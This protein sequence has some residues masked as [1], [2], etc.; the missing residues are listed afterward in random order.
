MGLIVQKYGGTSVAT[1][2][3]IKSVAD[4]II[5]SCADSHR[6]VVVVSAMGDTTDDLIA[7][8]SQVSSDPDD[9]ELDLLLST[10]ETIS[11]TLMAMALRAK[12]RDAISLTGG[13]AGIRTERAH[14]RA[15][16]T[17]IEPSRMLR[18]L[19]LGRVVIV[20]GFQGIT[21]DMDVTTLGRGGSDTT[22]VALAVALQADRCEF[23]KDVDGVL[24]ADPRIVPRARK[25]DEIEYEEMLELAQHGANVLHHRAVELA[26]VYG[27]P[28]VVRSS[29]N[30]SPGTYIHGG[31]GMEIRNK[32]R[33]IAHDI[34]VAKVTLV[35][36]PDRPGIASLLF[37][38]L[39]ENG[40]SVDVIVQN[41]SLHGV[42][43]L[44][45]TVSSQDLPRT[46][47]LVEDTAREIGAR[48]VVSSDGWA[49]VSIVGTGMQHTPGYA[50]RM[51]RSLSDQKINIEM[52]TTSEIRITCIIRAESVGDA[53]RGLHDAFQLETP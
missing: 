44:S 40:V 11:C 25:L 30:E 7:L 51:F 41:A 20:A 43:D 6:I 45:F 4:R 38:P 3:R 46:M 31:V 35:G 28:L 1:A 12:G 49:K 37:E 19:D 14:R 36:V 10:G 15:Q 29:F 32:V 42:T 34:D 52:I 21:D 23:Y 53:V 13:Q 48:E 33:G 24:T 39:A 17:G 50:A 27:V 5:R 26:S 9:R 2:D 8:A 22:A 18:E 47:R 16:I